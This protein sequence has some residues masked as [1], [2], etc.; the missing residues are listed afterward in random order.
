MKQCIVMLL[1][2]MLSACLQVKN[3]NGMWDKGFI[4][5]DLVGD[6][7]D[8]E[9]IVSG[10]AL[11]AAPELVSVRPVKDAYL[12]ILVGGVEKYQAKT[13]MGG[14][15]KF[16]LV[17]SVNEKKEMVYLLLNYKDDHGKMVSFD[18]DSEN[19]ELKKKYFKPT[20]EGDDEAVIDVLNDTILTDLGQT[21]AN[22]GLITKQWTFT[23]CD[24]TCVQ[25]LKDDD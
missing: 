4:D 10:N 18:L 16:L 2:L 20:P 19:P 11:K 12:Q 9:N 24:A 25:A 14:N 22:D 6:W 7:L 13:L 1:A 21:F 17:R 5:T 15:E 23:P 3:E 8:Q